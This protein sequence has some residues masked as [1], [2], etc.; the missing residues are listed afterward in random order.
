MNNL[1][2]SSFELRSLGF[3]QVTVLNLNPSPFNET[4]V[5]GL[6]VVA[7][8]QFR[9]R[10]DG[11]EMDQF[12]TIYQDLTGNDKIGQFEVDKTYRQG[13]VMCT[14]IIAEILCIVSFVV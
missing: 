8:A 13:R 4:V 9:D 2:L 3:E 14:Y 10:E 11:I 6:E 1:Y 7:I 5:Q 12:D